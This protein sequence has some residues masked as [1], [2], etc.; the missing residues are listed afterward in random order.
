MTSLELKD[1]LYG[2]GIGLAV[3][4]LKENKVAGPRFYRY[5]ELNK[6]PEFAARLVRR[7]MHGPLQGTRTGLYCYDCIFVNVPVTALPAQQ[8]G[9]RNWS[10]PGYKVDRTAV[11]VVAHEVAHH[12]E[13]ELQSRG[14]LTKTHGVAWRQLLQL[15]PKRVTGYEPVPSE[16]WAE[17]MRLF[18][19]NPQLLELGCPERYLFIRH[20]VGLKPTERRNWRRV[21]LNHPDYIRAAE[22]WIAK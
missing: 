10:Y 7:V 18:I 11:G 13:R 15:C 9:M 20:E 3:H 21:L 12:M 14:R 2:I 22:R 19:L 6:A 8:P 5:S 17:S 4:F 1:T 16:A